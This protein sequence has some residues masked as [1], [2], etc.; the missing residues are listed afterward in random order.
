MAA[1]VATTLLAALVPDGPAAG[2]PL[3]AMPGWP[4]PSGAGRRVQLALALALLA[5]GV[6]GFALRGLLPTP[7]PTFGPLLSALLGAVLAIP[8]ASVLAARTTDGITWILSLPFRVA[9]SAAYY[10][11]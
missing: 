7:V 11:V 6:G 2:P 10:S 5:L 8:S 1:G 3:E 4:G 9:D